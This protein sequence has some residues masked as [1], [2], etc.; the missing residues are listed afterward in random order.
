MARNLSR[1]QSL[2]LSGTR[3]TN[4]HDMSCHPHPH[5]PKKRVSFAAELSK[6]GGF[7]ECENLFFF[8]FSVYFDGAARVAHLI[9]QFYRHGNCLQKHKLSAA[10]KLTFCGKEKNV[11]REKRSQWYKKTKSR[12]GWI[13]EFFFQ[14]IIPMPGFMLC[15]ERDLI[16]HKAFRMFHTLTFGQYLT[17][18]AFPPPSCFQLTSTVQKGQLTYQRRVVHD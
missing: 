8:W 17:Q 5:P 2:P 11:R 15:S 4:M 3:T 7:Q 9:Y 14:I 10:V 13:S 1:T 16:I 6:N 12:R 18:L